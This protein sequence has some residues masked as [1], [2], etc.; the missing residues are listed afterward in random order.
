LVFDELFL[1]QIGLMAIKSKFKAKGLG[2]LFDKSISC[3]PYEKTLPY[4]L[5]AAQKRVIGQI[6]DDMETQKV[7]NRLV[8]GDVGSGK[9]A[10]AELAL[11]K[12]VKCGYQGTLMAPTELLAKQ[13]YEGITTGYLTGSVTSKEKE[14]ILTDL[15]SG[16]I[17][18]LIGTH[19]IIQDGVEFENLGLVVT[20]E[21]HR[22]GVNQRMMLTKK[23]NNP[24]VLVM[25]ATPIPRTLAVILYG[26]LDISVID[27]L[28]PGRQQIITRA[29]GEDGRDR[30]YNFVKNEIQNGRQGYIV[31][32]LIDDSEKVTAKSAESLYEELSQRFGEF[33]IALLHGEMKQNDKDKIMEAFYLGETNLLVSTVVIEV[34]INVPNATIML[35]ENA[36]RF[37]LAQLHQLRGRVGRGSE[38]SYCILI[39]QSS[40]EVA[41]LRAN[42][43]VASTDGFYIAEKDLQLRGP[44]EFFGTRQH[45]IPDLK[46]ADLIRHV[47]ILDTVKDEAKNLLEADPFL[48]QEENRRLKEKIQLKFN[49]NFDLNL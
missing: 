1:L 10:I 39:S 3:D 29:V 11:Y 15:R 7:M 49:D 9:T 43:M 14:E 32:P 45:G 17:Q 42:I 40:T 33:K 6:I 30:A 8:Q 35:I 46:L 12:A 27:E 5:T 38:Q 4:E 26:D 41:A 2:I 25:T 36:E 47:D 31:A 34:G 48:E 44:G 19:A 18:V 37:G 16:K 21:Q 13:H 28:P 24:D 20:D 22:F 23:G